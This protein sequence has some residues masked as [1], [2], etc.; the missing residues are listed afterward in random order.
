MKL[1]KILISSVLFFTLALTYSLTSAQDS[2]KNVFVSESSV[3]TASR[4]NTVSCHILPECMSPIY[5]WSSYREA[6]MWWITVSFK[7]DGTAECYNC[8]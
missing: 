7:F 4:L 5:W 2:D 1:K 8:Y 6:C 3:I